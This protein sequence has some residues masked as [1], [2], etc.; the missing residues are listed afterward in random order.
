MV[1]RKFLFWTSCTLKVAKLSV[2]SY[3]VNITFAIIIY[4][5]RTLSHWIFTYL[6]LFKIKMHWN[7]RPCNIV[8]SPSKNHIR[9]HTVLSFVTNKIHW[10]QQINDVCFPLKTR[11][12]DI[13]INIVGVVFTCNFMRQNITILID[14]K[15]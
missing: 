8:R 5:I 4:R 14:I 1:R 6:K 11:L 9:L 2:H 7:W 13:W 3:T 12:C 10:W 15:S